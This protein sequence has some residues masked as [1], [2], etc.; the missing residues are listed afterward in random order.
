MMC[1]EGEGTVRVGGGSGPAP[2]PGR[3][4]IYCLEPPA[5]QEGTSWR[6]CSRRDREPPRHICNVKNRRFLIHVNE[7]EAC[8]S[9]TLPRR[10][11]AAPAPGAR[12]RGPGRAPGLGRGARA[13]AH[14]ASGAGPRGHTEP[15]A[16]FKQ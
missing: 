9:N 4:E 5:L 16:P 7:V 11:G 14:R 15:R 13:L 2:A 12:G 6:N 3:L 1:V 10:A 8:G